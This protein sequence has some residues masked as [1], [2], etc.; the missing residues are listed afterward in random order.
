MDI[1]DFIFFGIGLSESI[2]NTLKEKQNEQLKNS[3][4]NLEEI[5]I[6]RNLNRKSTRFEDR[7]ERMSLVVKAMWELMK[8]TTGLNDTDLQRKII[9]LDMQDGQKDGRIRKKPL[10][11]RKCGSGVSYRFKKCMICGEEY[12]ELG[13]IDTF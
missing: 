10:Q 9:E 13:E 1:F 6:G 3:V 7:F 4:S 11:C 12:P 5:V 2:Y 8:E